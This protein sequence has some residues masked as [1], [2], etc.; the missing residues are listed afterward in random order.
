M[1]FNVKRLVESDYKTLCKW[2]KWWR[3]SPPPLTFLPETGF[4]VVKENIE[5]AACYVYLTNSK[6]AL[7]EWV[8][9]NPEYKES[10]RKDAIT[11]LIQATENVLKGQGIK[12]VFSFVRHK[13]LLKTHK[14]L[15]WQIDEIPSHEII[16]NLQS[17]EP[18][19]IF[20]KN[21][22]ECLKIQLQERGILDNKYQI[23]VD[24]LSL[25]TKGKIKTLTKMST[26][27]Q[28]TYQQTI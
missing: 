26:K 20:A 21:L 24:N 25:I 23:L 2:W 22:S 15:E 12:H 28:N 1:K 14:E 8:V 4:M 6:A 27:A 18:I 3:W 19:G 16:K 10:D 5:I 9:S 17:L 7:L 13:N 11:L